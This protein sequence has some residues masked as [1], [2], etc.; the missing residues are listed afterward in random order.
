LRG[1]NYFAKA[2]Q[3]DANTTLNR[4]FAKSRAGPV[5]STFMKMDI[6]K[7]LKIQD[8]DFRLVIG[9]TGIDYDPNKNEINIS[10]HGYSFDE[11]MSIFEQI[12]LPISTTPPFMVKDSIE[13][14]GELRS[15][16]ITIDKQGKVILIALTMRHNETVWIISMR[17]ASKKER[18][19]FAKL[20]D[21]RERIDIE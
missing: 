2:S 18:N 20:I 12:L 15:N 4:T 11:A 17:R 6:P 1:S 8:T 7:K 19:I 13:V 10:N 14:N 21:N 5:I 3:A 9:S 16:I